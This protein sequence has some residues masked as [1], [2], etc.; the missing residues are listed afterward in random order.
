MPLPLF[1]AVERGLQMALPFSD[2]GRRRPTP[3]SYSYDVPAA[4]QHQRHRPRD[5]VPAADT[6]IRPDAAPN[7]RRPSHRGD[8]SGSRRASTAASLDLASSRRSGWRTYHSIQVASTAACSNGIVVRVHRHDGVCPTRRPVA[9]AAA[10]RGR[11]GERRAQ[12]SGGQAQELLG[13]NNPQAHIMR[14]NFIWQLPKL[15]GAGRR[16][17][18]CSAARQ[19]L[20]PVGDLEL[21]RRRPAYSA[22]PTHQRNRLAS[23][24]ISFGQAPPTTTAC[25]RARSATRPGVGAA[26]PTRTGSSTPPAI[27]GAAARQRRSRVEQRLPPAPASSAVDRSSRSPGP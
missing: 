1:D 21:A 2:R 26:A 8:R 11:H 20:E 13:D 7:P 10:Q 24:D 14:A 22:T 25:V 19:R 27:A 5:G 3:A 4:D 16:V 9:P 17:G 18:A 15:S 6:R 12:R 23:V